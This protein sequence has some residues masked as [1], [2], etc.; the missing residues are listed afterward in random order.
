[1]AGDVGHAVTLVLEHRVVEGLPGVEFALVGIGW[2]GSERRQGVDAQVES[3]VGRPSTVVLESGSVAWVRG[4]DEHGITV[5]VGADARYLAGRYPHIERVVRT[6]H[7]QRGCAI[8]GGVV[9]YADDD[10]V[11]QDH[12]CRLEVEAQIEGVAAVAHIVTGSPRAETVLWA[13]RVRFGP[14]GDGLGDSGGSQQ[15]AGGCRGTGANDRVDVDRDRMGVAH[16]RHGRVLRVLGPVAHGHRDR[17]EHAVG[18]R[19]NDLVAELR[20]RSCFK[21]QANHV[22]WQRRR[23]GVVGRGGGECLGSTDGHAGHC[24]RR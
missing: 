11:G 9:G 16:Q 22:R 3:A 21:S 19:Q 17:R 1:M 10:V 7:V 13:G 12:T 6:G 20:C 8:V 24:G 2:R 14:P 4:V 15:S 18:S 23:Y 5:G